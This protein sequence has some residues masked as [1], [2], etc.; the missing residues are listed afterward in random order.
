MAWIQQKHFLSLDNLIL[1]LKRIPETMI[2]EG[3][4][5]S[6]NYSVFS[7]WPFLLGLRFIFFDQLFD[8]EEEDQKGWSFSFQKKLSKHLNSNLISNRPPF[9]HN[10]VY[11][12]DNDQEH[13]CSLQFEK[14]EIDNHDLENQNGEQLSF[15]FSFI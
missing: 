14:A 13:H 11:N 4:D 5:E 12:L 6:L 2:E 9:L 3:C 1:V 8:D 15:H 10:L 7:K